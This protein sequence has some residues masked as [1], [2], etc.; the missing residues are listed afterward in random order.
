M[1]G[2]RLRFEQTFIRVVLLVSLILVSHPSDATI[3]WEKTFRVSTK[4]LV[5]SFGQSRGEHLTWNSYAAGKHTLYYRSLFPLKKPVKL[6]QGKYDMQPTIAHSAKHVVVGALITE[7]NIS[8]LKLYVSD[9]QEDFDTEDGPFGDLLVF[10]PHME[11]DGKYF[12][13]FVLGSGSSNKFAVYHSRSTD[14][15]SWSSPSKISGDLETGE[16]GSFFP[17]LSINGSRMDLAFQRRQG[18]ERLDEI[19]FMQSTSYG[20]SWSDPQKV[21]S[22]SW[23]DFAPD[24]WRN[25]Q[26]LHMVW[27]ARPGVREIRYRLYKEGSW[28]V[29]RTVS[30]GQGQCFSPV[31]LQSRQG[32]LQAVWYGYKGGGKKS[33]LF[34]RFLDGGKVQEI[35]STGIRDI[36]KFSGKK[37][38]IVY[39]AGGALYERL[40]DETVA[41]VKLKS[42]HPRN[43][44]T[45]NRNINFS[46]NAPKDSSGLAGFGIILDE[47]PDSVPATSNLG[48]GVKTYRQ[49]NLLSGIHYF[50]IRTFDRAGNGSKTVHYKFGIDSE[51]PGLPTI[52]SDTHNNKKA[53][54]GNK[55]R[56][57]LASFD[58]SGIAYYKYS[59]SK[60][61]GDPLKAVSKQDK[62]LFT[63][64]PAGKYFLKVVAIDGVVNRSPVKTSSILVSTPVAGPEGQPGPS[65]ELPPLNK[66]E[67][68]TRRRMTM[69]V[70]G[71][72]PE[73]IVEVAWNLADGQTDPLQ[74]GTRRKV[75]LKAEKQGRLKINFKKSGNYFVNVKVRY[76]YAGWSAASNKPVEVLL[77]KGGRKYVP[78][79]IEVVAAGEKVAKRKSLA[80]SSFTVDFKWPGLKAVNYSITDEPH[81]PGKKKKYKKW[82]KT[83]ELSPG[84]WYLS[85]RLY[86]KAGWSGVVHR[87]LVIKEAPPETAG[88]VIGWPQVAAV[89][90]A[91]VVG[92]AGSFALFHE[93]MVFAWNKAVWWL[94]P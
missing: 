78:P 84:T 94:R 27:Q 35:G 42:S 5:T 87:R 70:M 43:G 69:L 76:R 54:P 80:Q 61:A 9:D 41:S 82:K 7:D 62:L 72:I 65:L 48:P 75:T 22:N 3:G 4:G 67:Q 86:G 47:S 29:Y 46:W 52:S 36:R 89:A 33:L 58:D 38:G 6:S 56:F 63:N 74:D 92:V 40:L 68:W 45:R 37:R 90:V 71:S 13:L 49:K 81:D 17:A 91:M 39:L 60:D 57:A 25:K 10:S 55:I 83:I 85:A 15:E 77:K 12:Q 93:R 44:V 23:Q 31:I 16:W 1:R 26:G 19:Y 79:E 24:L 21:T 14:G 28:S 11:W 20:S 2:W 18:K 34:S 73:D 64:R 51:K 8:R 66:Q 53:K 30:D 32:G 50:H 88:V 59:F